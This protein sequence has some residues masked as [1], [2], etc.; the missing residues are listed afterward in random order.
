MNS[1]V[2]TDFRDKRVTVAGLGRFG[3]GI[4][5]SRW[6]AGQG[7]RV[8]VTDKDPA[9]KLA[10]SVRQLKGL[11]IT[12]RLGEHRVEDFTGCDL[13]VTSPALPP[14]NPYLVAARTAGVPITTEIRLFVER[15]PCRVIGVTGTKGKSTTTAM[16]GR[17]LQTRFKTWVGGNIGKSLLSDLPAMVPQSDLV[18]LELSSYMLEHLKLMQ[19][20]PHV[21]VVTMVSADHLDWHGGIDNYLEAKRHI[22]RFQKP[23]DHA[24]LCEDTEL[25]RSFAVIARSKVHY[26][27]LKRG[28]PLDLLIAGRHNQLNAQAALAAAGVM[29]VSRDECQR[30]VADFRG[31]PHRLEIVHEAAGVS[32]VN[33]SIATIPDAAVA[34]LQAFP[35]RSVIQ[36]VGGHD[37][38]LDMR[39][40]CDAL[41]G[42][43]KAVLTLG[44]TGPAL[45]RMVRSHPQPT[46][47][48][49]CGDLATAVKQARQL[50]SAGDTV[51]LS[52]GCA[53]YDQFENFE[54]RGEQF[55][56]LARQAAPA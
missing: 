38:H 33:D 14:A 9:E 32:W 42:R 28:V 43:A 1:D 56:A 27:G 53:S 23:G 51:L 26:Y 39:P 40:M 2:I 30:A 22:V 41:A 16:L 29:G 46:T 13:V 36:I 11:P 54:K 37:K 15:C 52:T 10:D 4:A 5:V 35:A 49:E 24:V 6:L 18:L 55:A 44:A 50:A 47:V 8:L 3:G 48:V 34:A 19:W 20:S 31:L 7:A 25:S 21:A 17:M 45:A 12:F